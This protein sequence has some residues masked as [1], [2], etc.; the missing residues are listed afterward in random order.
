MS[1][2]TVER[3]TEATTLI[4][5]DGTIVLEI[6]AGHGSTRHYSFDQETFARFARQMALDASLTGKAYRTLE[7]CR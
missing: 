7:G 6:T 1:T 5:R 2:I 4:H 3:V